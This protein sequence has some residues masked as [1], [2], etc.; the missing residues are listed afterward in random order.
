[1]DV[2]IAMLG[3]FAVTVAAVRCP[4]TPGRAGG[5]GVAG[6]AARPRRR[7]APAP[8]A[9]HRRAVA[10]P[11]RS[12]PPRPRLHKAAHYARRALGATP[13]PR[14]WCCA[15]TWSRCC[16][17]ADV[18][19]DA[20]RVPRGARRRRWLR[21]PPSG[22]RRRWPRTAGRCCPRTSTSR[23]PHEAREPCAVLHRDLLRLAGRW[24][25]LVAAGPGRRA[26]PPGAGPAL[27]RRAAT[28]AR[29]CASSSGWSRRCGASSARRRAPR[30]RRRCAP[31]CS[32]GAV[33]RRPP[34]RR[35]R[36]RGWSAA[37]GV[38]D[39]S[40]RGHGPR[41]RAAAAARCC[42]TGPAGV[43]QVR[44]A[45][46]GRRAGP[47]G[48]AGGSPGARRP[49]SRAPWPYAPVLE[50]FGDLC[51]QH[52]ALLDG[53]DDV[54]RRRDRPGAVRRAGRLERRDARTSGCSSRPPSCCGWPRPGA[55][56]C[57]SWTTCTRRTR[58]R[59]GCC[60]TSPDAR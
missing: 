50:A 31:S 12:T 55:G 35:G 60:T 44:G 40:A 56:C 36:A 54:Y 53:L 2:Q 7:P 59:C 5:A 23:G 4:P 34:P 15:T 3:G 10:R 8:R 26:G 45:R 25:E 48:A 58:R 33:D 52:P 13:A 14:S 46:P 17:D 57:S 30:P 41:R 22:R 38:G 47:A 20:V 21:A 16:P 32:P 49:R 42:V 28:Y 39:G 27:A 29:P 19:V 43:G 11:S 37:R 18:R 1:M 24:E 6:Q 51:R 9:G